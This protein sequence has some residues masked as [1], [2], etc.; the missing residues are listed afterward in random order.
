MSRSYKKVF[1]AKQKNDGFMKKYSSKIIRKESFDEEIEEAGEVKER[2][3]FK[4]LIDPWD[5]CD[6][7]FFLTK[8]ELLKMMEENKNDK[9]FLRNIYSAYRNK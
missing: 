2:A 6:W 8:S 3:F 7:S 9:N 1:I 4:K 5:I